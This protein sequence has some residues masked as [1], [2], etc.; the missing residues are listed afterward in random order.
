MRD[1]EVNAITELLR[2]GATVVNIGPNGES[3]PD[4]SKRAFDP[5]QDTDI[6][7]GSLVDL[8]SGTW[9]GP[10]LQVVNIDRWEHGGSP[11]QGSGTR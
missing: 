4:G 8:P 6:P 9:S 3:R 7:V 11:S 2:R 10:A 5:L 1:R